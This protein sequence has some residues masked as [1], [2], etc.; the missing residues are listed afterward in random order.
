MFYFNNFYFNNGFII[1]I[2][3]WHQTAYILGELGKYFWKEEH[4]LS[5]QIICLEPINLCINEAGP[6]SYD[7]T[8]KL[9]SLV[10][11]IQKVE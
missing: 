1:E 2:K 10:Q 4:L 6:R 5:K 8:G 7:I 11:R 9:G 3:A